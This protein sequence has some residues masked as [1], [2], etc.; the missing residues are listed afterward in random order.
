MTTDSNSLRHPGDATSASPSTSIHEKTQPAHASQAEAAA[1]TTV[2]APSKEDSDP[3]KA[4]HTHGCSQEEPSR[5]TASSNA[6]SIPET[7]AAPTSPGDF[8]TEDNEHISGFKLYIALFSIISVFFLVLLDFSI[9]STAIPYITS[10]FQRLQ[11]IGWYGS[12]YVLSSATL[13]PLSGKFYTYL[14]AKQTF[15]FFVMIFEIGSLLCAVSTSSTF[16]IL[17]RAVA[18]MGSS[19]LENGALTLIA[20]AVP[21]HKRPLYNGIVFGVCQTGIV[22]GPL[23]GGALTQYVSWRW[24]FYINLPIG[25]VSSLFLFF[26]HIPD[27][28]LKPPFSFALLRSIVPNLDLTGLALF[29]PTTLMFLLAL[30]W[31]ST[32][33]RWSSPTVIGLFAGSGV[34]LILFGSWEWHVGERSLIPF[35]LVKRRIVWASTVQNASLFVNNYVGVNYVPIYFQAVKGVGPSLSGVYTLPSILTQLLCLIVSGALAGVP[36][37]LAALTC[38]N[39]M[40]INLLQAITSVQNAV[41]PAESPSVIAFMVFVENLSAAIFTIVGNAIFTQTLVKQVAVRAPSVSS[42]AVLK[43]GGSAEAV[44]ALLPPGSPELYGLLLAFSESVNAV[45]YLL[46]ALAVVSFSAAWGMGWVDIRKKAPT[47][48]RA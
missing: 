16:F 31:G 26:T 43:V 29:V 20:G 18:G 11:D 45:F 38:T 24:C 25:A 22:L 44:R 6:P 33:H 15:L 32:E 42:E 35:H 17:G 10:D 47:T 8:G 21:L 39:M 36:S 30:E 34:A 12:A 28:T 46:S 41:T 14:N 27:E 48:D 19:G 40:G 37:M 7:A 4:V 5:M 9:L 2:V 13:Q 23:I 3:E 1:G